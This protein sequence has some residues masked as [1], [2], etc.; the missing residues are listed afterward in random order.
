MIASIGSVSEATLRTED[1]LR[2]FTSTLESLDE[3]KVY[4]TLVAE[5][6]ELAGRS[7]TWSDSDSEQASCLVNEE[8]PDLLQQFAPEGAYFGTLEGDGACFGFWMEEP[9]PEV[10]D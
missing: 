7:E 1:L 6:Y 3:F 2:A 4:A 9:E 8:L 5:C 10:D